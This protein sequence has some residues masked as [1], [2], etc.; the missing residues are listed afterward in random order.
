MFMNIP[1]RT[2]AIGKSERYARKAS[3]CGSK[4]QQNSTP[5]SL[6]AYAIRYVQPFAS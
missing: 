3:H 1:V 4:Q 5:R 2:A 6:F